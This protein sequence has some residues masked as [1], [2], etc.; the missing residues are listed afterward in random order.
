MKDKYS[1][2]GDCNYLGGCEDCSIE[3]LQKKLKEKLQDL[4]YKDNNIEDLKCCGN[5][6]NSSSCGDQ[7]ELCS[8]W[9]Y[10][11]KTKEDRSC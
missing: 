10:D 1:P 4:K 5:C 9:V 6:G 11:G 8:E 3:I 7:K 2:C